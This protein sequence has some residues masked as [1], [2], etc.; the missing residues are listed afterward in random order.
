MNCRDIRPHESQQ[1][2]LLYGCCQPGIQYVQGVAVIPSF[3][4]F[5]SEEANVA[6]KSP[7]EWP[8]VDNVL[9]S[10]CNVPLQI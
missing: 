2:L 4:R 9:S 6:A 3:V 10:S 7:K 5:I 1:F 8:F